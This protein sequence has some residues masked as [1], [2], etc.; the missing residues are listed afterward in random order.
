VI[1]VAFCTSG[2]GVG[3]AETALLKTIRELDPRSFAA[4]VISVTEGGAVA[5]QMREAGIRVI[6]IG[7]KPGRPDP[8]AVLKL[9]RILVREAPVLLQTM[10]YEA[11]LYGLVAGRLAKVPRIVWGLRCSN[12]DYRRYGIGAR[13]AFEGNRLLSC[14]PDAIIA[15]SE[16]GRRFHIRRGFRGDRM[17]VVPNGF[18]ID[19]FQPDEQTRKAMRSELGIGPEVLLVGMVGRFDP[20]KDHKTFIDAAAHV[21]TKSVEFVMAGEDVASEGPVGIW[22]TQAGLKDRVHLLGRRSDVPGLMTAFDLFVSSSAFG[23]GFPNVVGEAMATGVP[24]VVT[25]V[26]DSARL[27]GD[28]GRAVPPC[29]PEALAGEIDRI[30]GLSENERREMGRRARTRVQ[31]RFEIQSIVRDLERFYLDLVSGHHGVEAR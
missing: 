27:V 14:C 31:E 3:G 30:L 20:M 21:R 9:R 8:R 2:L 10:M 13:L 22:A 1:K 28:T 25:D 24:C 6:C 23:E 11:N 16:A 19:R 4:S 17:R 18:E 15:N 29:R 12:M 5:D 26:G 7:K